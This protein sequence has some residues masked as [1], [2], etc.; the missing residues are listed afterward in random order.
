MNDD[1]RCATHDAPSTAPCARCGTFLC[2]ACVTENGF[3]APC[4]ARR[5]PPRGLDPLL[6]ASFGC[7]AVGAFS[8][9]FGRHFGPFG[10][11]VCCACPLGALFGLFGL[12]EQRSPKLALL[13]TALNVSP[14]LALIAFVVITQPT[15]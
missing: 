3:C 8:L 13:A 5:V 15:V 7:F 2:G 12:L 4:V 10:G 9:A 14:A 6:L 1:A 11:L